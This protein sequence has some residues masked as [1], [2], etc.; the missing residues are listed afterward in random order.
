MNATTYRLGPGQSALRRG[1]VSTPGR[2]YLV[3]FATHGRQPWFADHETARACARAITDPQLWL[4]S[5][6][7]AWV[8]MPDHWHGLLAL[9]RDD[10]LSHRVGL[11]K[12]NTSRAVAM[13]LPGSED[14]WAR[15]FHD[16]VLPDQRTALFHAANYL[17][18]NPVRA[19]LVTDVGA[20]PYWDTVWLQR[21]TRTD[22]S[23]TAYESPTVGAA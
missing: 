12:S 23:P 19:G 18:N 9:G 15:S 6:L 7:L 4:R 22:E 17:V 13:R 5:R 20:Y 3:T 1:R 16:R 2:I 11:L 21:A 14:V 10:S 8:L